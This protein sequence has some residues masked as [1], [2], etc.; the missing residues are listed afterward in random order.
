MSEHKVLMFCVNCIGLHP[1][2]LPDA[3]EVNLRL[4][5]PQ[6]LVALK[7]MKFEE[8]KLEHYANGT[9]TLCGRSYD[10]EGDLDE[11][12]NLTAKKVEESITDCDIQGV[13]TEYINKI[14][15]NC[16]K[17][18][19]LLWANRA[20]ITP[21]HQ[22]MM[23]FSGRLAFLITKIDEDLEKRNTNQVDLGYLEGLLK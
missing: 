17:T 21:E 16:L 22:A 18:W 14:V 2:E 4:Q 9:C 19:K 10:E 11:S 20:T 1:D 3:K 8:K 23:T 5:S 12:W 15:A 13:T 7:K 6:K